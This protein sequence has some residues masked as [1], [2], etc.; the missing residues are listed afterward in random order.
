[1][2]PAVDDPGLAFAML[3][4]TSEFADRTPLPDQQWPDGGDQQQGEDDAAT[5]LRTEG[6]AILHLEITRASRGETE[7]FRLLI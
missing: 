2:R 6:R 5:A 1:M 3:S 4:L 7:P